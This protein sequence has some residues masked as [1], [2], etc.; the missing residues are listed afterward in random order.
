MLD[1]ESFTFTLNMV[2]KEWLCKIHCIALIKQTRSSKK[3]CDFFFL[4]IS[5][6]N[7]KMQ[8]RKKKNWRIARRCLFKRDLWRT[9]LKQ[10][11]NSWDTFLGSYF[12]KLWCSY[13]PRWSTISLHFRFLRAGLSVLFF[14]TWL[15]Q[16]W[17]T[18]KQIYWF[19]TTM[20]FNQIVIAFR[21]W[22]RD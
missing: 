1:S 22:T 6:P 18:Q 12:H 2:L 10:L 19:N 16:P 8:S 3:I 21:H 15:I 7:K 17:T 13:C 14:P 9:C 5:G 20:Y 4:S 11:R